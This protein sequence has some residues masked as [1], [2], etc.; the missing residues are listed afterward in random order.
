M[1]SE[2]SKTSDPQVLLINLTDQTNLKKSDKYVVLS[3][4]SS[5]YRWKNIINLKY[6]PQHGIKSLKNLIDDTAPKT[7]FS[8][9]KCSEKIIFPKKNYSGI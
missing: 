4:V 5:Y 7:M 2:K 3:N 8:F 9:F 1:N 6:Q